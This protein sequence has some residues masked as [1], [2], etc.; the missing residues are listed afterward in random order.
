MEYIWSVSKVIKKDS[1]G[2]LSDVI[3]EVLYLCELVVEEDY[4]ILVESLV[5]LKEPKDGFTSYS[6]LSEDLILGWIPADVKKLVESDMLNTS[7]KRE[8]K[9]F[10]EKL[11][12]VS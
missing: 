4:S 3:V 10:E 9:E 8:P 11:P 1:L 5:K 6:E 12:W 7:I 2:G